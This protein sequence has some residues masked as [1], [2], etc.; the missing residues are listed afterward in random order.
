MRY[1]VVWLISLYQRWISPYK[2]FSC[3]HDAR[4]QSGSCSHE[5]KSLLLKH[6]LL[7][8]L[9][10]IRLR[11][12]ACRSAYQELASQRADLPC[13]V[14]C[15]LDLFDCGGIGKSTSASLDCVS[16]CDP[17]VDSKKL[18]KREARVCITVMVIA[19]LLVSYF[20]YGRGVA[21]VTVQDNGLEKQSLFTRLAQREQPEIRVL[22]VLDGKKVY[23]NIVP[24]VQTITA[25][26]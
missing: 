11:F 14:S 26:K 10:L 20:F 6:G 12:K 21:S 18:S 4:Y 25:N 9:P 7:K 13:D 3:A 19:I 24:L 23:T 5:T 16:F 17:F 1:F 22:V 2:G 15:G 8:A